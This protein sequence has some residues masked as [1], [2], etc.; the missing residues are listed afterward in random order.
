MAE[1]PKRYVS[2]IVTKGQIGHEAV[3]SGVSTEYT[4]LAL[5]NILG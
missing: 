5:H 4:G 2:Y 3:M 1:T